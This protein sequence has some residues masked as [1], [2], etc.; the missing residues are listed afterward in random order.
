[1]K[2][3]NFLLTTVLAGLLALPAFARDNFALLIGANDYPNLDQQF[4]L[5]GPSNDV[6]LVASCR[7]VGVSTLIK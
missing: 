2:T 1:M 4:W 6:K 3:R 5:K 7:L